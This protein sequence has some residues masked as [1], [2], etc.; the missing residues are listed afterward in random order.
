MPL[1]CLQT[2]YISP[3][4]LVIS[5]SRLWDFS[6]YLTF[7]FNFFNCNG[8]PRNLLAES[9]EEVVSK[10]KGRFQWRYWF[11]DFMYLDILRQ[12]TID[13]LCALTRISNR[14]RMRTPILRKSDDTPV[15]SRRPNYF[16]LRCWA[17]DFSYHLKSSKVKPTHMCFADD[18]LILRNGSSISLREILNIFQD[19]Y[20]IPYEA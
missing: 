13:L 11:Q 15:N 14:S 20:S 1:L 17:A 7:I 2:L 19:F 8:Y 4:S 12:L 6:R 16:V 9:E 10:L 3:V 18:V 5:H